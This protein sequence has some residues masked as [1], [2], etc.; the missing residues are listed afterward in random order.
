MDDTGHKHWINS[1][2]F[3]DC[4]AE[5]LYGECHYTECRGALQLGWGW[6]VLCISLKL[7]SPLIYR[8]KF[9]LRISPSLFKIFRWQ[10]HRLNYVKIQG[11]YSQPFILLVTS[12]MVQKAIVFVRGKLFRPVQCNTLTYW[13]HLWRKWR[14]VNMI[15]GVVFTILHFL[16]SLP[17]GTIS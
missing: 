12:L 6:G 2:T 11:P 13:A 15:P 3:S 14:V 1:A 8:L 9:F 4:F 17:Y 10:T 16:R 7:Q 5:C